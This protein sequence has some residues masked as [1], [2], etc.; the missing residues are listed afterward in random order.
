MLDSNCLS[1]AEQ[2]LPYQLL[3][4]GRRTSLSY[5]ATQQTTSLDTQLRSA[6]RES[7]SA[8]LQT[9]SLPPPLYSL[10]SLCSTLQSSHCLP[11][12]TLHLKVMTMEQCLYVM[13]LPDHLLT[14]NGT[15]APIEMWSDLVNGTANELFISKPPME[16]EGWY[17]CRAYTDNAW[18]QSGNEDLTVLISRMPIQWI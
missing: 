13:L 2:T 12:T 10:P 15:G 7:I 1:P 11:Q 14:T 18:V 3:I 8:S 17:R 4:V 5:R 9:P 16:S 6:T